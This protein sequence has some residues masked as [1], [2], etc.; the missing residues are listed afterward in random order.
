M[1][2][3]ALGRVSQEKEKRVSHEIEKRLREEEEERYGGM[4]ESTAKRKQAFVQFIIKT[5]L[6]DLFFFYE[7]G[8]TCEL[9]DP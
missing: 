2:Q 7:W 5:E 1:A 9:K 6:H 8:V 4:V 3:R